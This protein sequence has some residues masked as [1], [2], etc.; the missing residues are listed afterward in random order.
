MY[1]CAIT[2]CSPSIDKLVNF[3]C[4]R[5]VGLHVLCIYYMCVCVC[6]C[7]MSYVCLLV[8]I[9]MQQENITVVVA[10]IFIIVLASHK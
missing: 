2:L 3:T 5:I 7:V 9:Y 4:L 1:V 8:Y 10:L 6:V